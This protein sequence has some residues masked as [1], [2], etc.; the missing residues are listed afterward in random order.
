MPAGNIR[1]LKFHEV[2]DGFEVAGVVLSAKRVVESW[3]IAVQYI[4]SEGGEDCTQTAS[5]GSI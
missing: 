2:T 5:Q 3:T 4:L 1:Y